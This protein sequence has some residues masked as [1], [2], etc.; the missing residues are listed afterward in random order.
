MQCECNVFGK[1]IIHKADVIIKFHQEI[2]MISV[3]ILI[4][5]K[6]MI[7]ASGLDGFTLVQ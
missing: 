4:T 7:N 2:Y 1:R 6:D 5:N 3:F